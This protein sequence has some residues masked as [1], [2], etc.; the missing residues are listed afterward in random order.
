MKPFNGALQGK[1]RP[2]RINIGLLGGKTRF[3]ALL[4]GLSTRHIN[5]FPALGGFRQHS[6]FVVGYFRETA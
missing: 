4:G 3:R 5:A 2:H 6:E 1:L